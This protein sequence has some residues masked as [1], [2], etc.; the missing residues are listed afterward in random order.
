MVTIMIGT[1]LLNNGYVSLINC[2]FTE[3]DI[4]KFAGISYS[5]EKGPGI[6]K[7]IDL[8]HYSPLEFASV[9]FKIKAPIFVARQWMRHR[10]GKY[11]EKSLRYCKANPSFYTPKDSEFKKE[12]NDFFC[13]SLDLY[14]GLIQNGEP[15]ELARAVLPVSLY[16]EFYFQMDMRNFMNF[17][18]LRLHESAQKEIR[19]YAKAML[20]LIEPHFPT[21]YSHLSNI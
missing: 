15:K 12:Y 7:L 4:S 11:M 19:D 8:E 17:M 3:E 6:Q 2:N 18:K 21:I 20:K 5:S 16:T 14:F 10:T 1:D 13:K 9:T